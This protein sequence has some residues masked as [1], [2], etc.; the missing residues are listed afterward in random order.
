MEI[1]ELEL[2]L[3]QFIGGIQGIK[4]LQAQRFY[5]RNT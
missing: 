4:V 5:N 3:V 2:I 1:D